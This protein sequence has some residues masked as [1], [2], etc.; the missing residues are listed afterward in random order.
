VT[1]ST[2]VIFPNEIQQKK[3]GGKKRKNVRYELVNVKLRILHFMGPYFIFYQFRMKIFYDSSFLFV[4][5]KE[6][7]EECLE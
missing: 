2:I 6:R 4:G 1:V 3:W 5:I 7:I